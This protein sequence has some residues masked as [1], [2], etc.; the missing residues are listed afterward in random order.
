MPEAGIR[1]ADREGGLWL[2]P[3]SLSSAFAPERRCSMKE[4][5]SLCPK[6]GLWVTSS[7]KP[8]L[9]QFSWRGWQT[10]RWSKHLFGADLLKISRAGSGV[11]QWTASL[12]ASRAS[13]GAPPA[14]SSAK[15]TTDGYG[16]QSLESSTTPKPPRFFLKMF[17]ASLW[18]SDSIAYSETLP[19]SGS[20]RSGV[21]SPQ[22]MWEP[23]ISANA[24][25][26]WPSTRAEDAES[27]G[28]HPATSHSGDSLTGVIKTWKTPHGFSAGNGPDGN[29]FSTQV[30]NWA[31]PSASMPNDGESPESWQARISE[32]KSRGIN[33]NGAGVPLGLEARLWQT[34]AS[35]SFRSR[36]GDRVDEMGLDQQARMFWPT[37][38][39]MSGG[40]ESSARKKE[41]GRMESGGSDLEAVAQHW[42]TARA[43]DHKGSAKE[44][45][46]RGQLDEAAEQIF[47]PPAQAI[48]DGRKSSESTDTSV[49]QSPLVASVS[50]GTTRP[51]LSK[52]RRLNPAFAAWLM[53]MPWWWTS[54]G[55]ISF[56]QSEME[57]WRSRQRSLLQ[58][59]LGGS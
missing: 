46:R 56:A 6:R 44:G 51:D 59:F 30:R 7:G 34:P 57:S 35:D 28:N 9:R 5:A 4:F 54:I 33:G 10:R 17:Q 15:P 11:E 47:S 38:D 14:A 23:P 40:P 21:V 45:Q 1:G 36:G 31:T 42:P 26:F 12:R 58:F 22:P 24:F 53:G 55:P 43:N 2:I 16:R 50:G 25:S 13:R 27:C 48:P 3:H 32:L 18:D 8:T 37:P 39:S 49:P 52:R 29:E 20:M 19:R 41:L